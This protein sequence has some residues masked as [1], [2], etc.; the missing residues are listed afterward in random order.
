MNEKGENDIKYLMKN[1]KNDFVEKK[2][3]GFK[4]I[5]MKDVMPS[6]SSSP[7][8]RN[9]GIN[10]QIRSKNKKGSPKVTAKPKIKA[11]KTTIRANNKITKMKINTKEFKPKIRIKP[12]RR[13]RKSHDQF[14]ADFIDEFKVDFPE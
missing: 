7:K 13:L 12:T 6:S 4:P 14:D 1:F 9:K 5:Q 8:T 11:M 3:V 2:S 10:V